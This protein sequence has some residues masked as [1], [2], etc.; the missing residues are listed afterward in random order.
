MSENPAEAG[1]PPVRASDAERDHAAEAL[2]VAYAEGRVTSDELDERVTVAYAA[3]TR[4]DLRDL[5]SDLPGA[6][7]APVAGDWPPAAGLPVLWP[8]AIPGTGT[9]INWCLLVCLLC[10]FPPAGIVYLV[11]ACRRQ[12]RPP[13]VT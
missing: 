2:R 6:L 1:V 5:L 13:A 10:A 7:S 12:P 3:K 9:Q 4:A 11:L 8:D